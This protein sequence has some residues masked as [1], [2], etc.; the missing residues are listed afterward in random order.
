MN[1]E[2]IKI[3]VK[4]ILDYIKYKYVS[5]KE[6]KTIIDN[7]SNVDDKNYSSDKD[8]IS[9]TSNRRIQKVG[10][11][12]GQLSEQ[13]L[14]KGNS[15]FQKDKS[16][17]YSKEYINGYVLRSVGDLDDNKLYI[18]ASNIPVINIGDITIS[19]DNNTARLIKMENIERFKLGK[20]YYL[21]GENNRHIKMVANYK[22]GYEDYFGFTN[23][24]KLRESAE[25]SSFRFYCDGDYYGQGIDAGAENIY[26]KD[27]TT[28]ENSSNTDYIE[29]SLD[30][31]LKRIGD[32]YDSLDL[33]TGLLKRFIGSRK[34]KNGDES[35]HNVLTDYNTTFYILEQ[36]IEK[37]IDI[38]QWR[39][40]LLENSY[41]ILDNNI[42]PTVTLK[43]RNSNVKYVEGYSNPLLKGAAGD[44]IEDDSRF[45][46]NN[47]NYIPDKY[48]FKID[49]KTALLLHDTNIFGN[50]NVLIKDFPYDSRKFQLQGFINAKDIKDEVKMAMNLPNEAVPNGAQ[51]RMRV[52]GWF[53][54]ESAEIP[55]GYKVIN[56][57]GG[58]YII[59]G[60]KYPKKA[61]VHIANLTVLGY[62]ESTK[63]WEILNNP[64]NIYGKFYYEDFHNETFLNP[65]DS[66]SNHIY[67]AEIDSSSSGRL[68]HLWCNQHYVSDLDTDFKYI[69][70]YM[71]AWVTGDGSGSSNSDVADI[72]VSNA[73][74]DVRVNYDTSV[75]EMCGGRF[76]KLKNYP[77]RCY[78]TNLNA[79]LADE[80]VT[81]GLIDK[82]QYS[83]AR[84]Y[85]RSYD[86]PRAPMKGE[87]YFDYE[88]NK[89]LYW[90]G[91]QW[92]DSQ[93]KIEN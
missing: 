49:K 61:F 36:P 60:K 26:F 75:R 6:I 39:L 33:K 46:N 37:K 10:S 20:S 41:L 67:T 47:Y 38:T 5:K 16:K 15:L 55:S 72:F 85:G 8:I 44:G 40:R 48:T 54:F 83:A 31:S 68:L 30:S 24:F 13:I 9:L 1:T 12:I 66:I 82:I 51:M 78:A 84:V 63:G 90:N 18:K 70:V 80:Y 79:D 43:Y 71:D 87:Y 50:G 88:V 53:P 56:A 4:E 42:I 35:D 52:S 69:C 32:I 57:W 89:I 65:A 92:V 27:M 45:F 22:E 86:R 23:I 14:V 19:Y 74:S 73:G 81:Q 3:L 2:N 29:I 93:G 7:L 28:K 59:K 91:S 77:R 34:Y 62:R 11:S 58:V 25:L 76:I 21:Y 17:I 64:D